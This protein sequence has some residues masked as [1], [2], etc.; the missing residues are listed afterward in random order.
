MNTE[1]EGPG[2]L[3][4]V[5]HTTRYP[6]PHWKTGL[7]AGQRHDHS[8]LALLEITWELKG[9]SKWDYS[10]IFEPRLTIRGFERV[11]LLTSYEKIYDIVE[12][13]LEVLE[14]RVRAETF[15]ADPKSELIIDAGGPGTPIVDC[16][17]R[18]L[19]RGVR[20]TPVMIT[21]G[22]HENP[23][24]DGYRS[25]PRRALI[26]EL[27]QL[28][29]FGIL[30]CPDNLPGFDEFREE[31]LE[32]SGE[33]SHPASHEFHDDL[34][35]STALAAWAALRDIEELRPGKKKE[36][37]RPKTPFPLQY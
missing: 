35:M 16:M 2:E 25:V 17:R 9:R 37:Q 18:T 7:D 19:R 20:I 4:Y 21:G 15:R 11:P 6:Q 5:Q 31:L 34:V 10:H 29:R 27:L 23:L 13:K 12:E 36:G 22:R 32:L 28:I 30:R 14:Q 3:F 8:A 26:T 1:F 33:T 24:Q